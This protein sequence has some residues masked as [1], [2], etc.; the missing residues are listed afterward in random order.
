MRAVEARSEPRLTSRTLAASA[1]ERKTK[2]RGG[3]PPSLGLISGQE[4]GFSRSLGGE[5]RTVRDREMSQVKKPR[6]W[7]LLLGPKMEVAYV[8]PSLAPLLGCTPEDFEG[9][10]LLDMLHPEVRTNFAASDAARVLTI[11]LKCAG[12]CACRRGLCRFSSDGNASRIGYAMPHAP[13]H[14]AGVSRGRGDD[15]RYQ[16]LCSFLY[17]RR[18]VDAAEFC[19]A[20]RAARSHSAGARDAQ[21]PFFC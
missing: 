13:S 12:T 4:V 19:F 21:R 17:D 5:L 6:A 11:L 20:A 18:R 7:L 10:G 14:N 9:T 2:T 1:A 16:Q 3:L 8:S 15:Q